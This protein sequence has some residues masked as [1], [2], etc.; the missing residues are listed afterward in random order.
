MLQ[1]QLPKDMTVQAWQSCR[2]LLLL[3]IQFL[4]N[5]FKQS[6]LCA[7]VVVSLHLEL[8]LQPAAAHVQLLFCSC[9]SLACLRH[10]WRDSKPC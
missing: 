4:K 2:R 10:F 7:A 1:C 8:Q 9:L 3:Q 5:A 6:F